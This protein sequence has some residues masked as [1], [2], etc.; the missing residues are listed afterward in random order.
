L[1]LSSELKTIKLYSNDP[2]QEISEVVVLGNFGMKS[3]QITSEMLPGGDLYDIYY[4]NLEL[5]R[6]RLLDNPLQPGQFMI[7]AN[8]KTKLEDDL[9][10]T[11]SL[12]SSS[13][14]ILNIYPNPTQ[15]ILNIVF[16]SRQRYNLTFFDSNGRLVDNNKHEG[17]VLEKDISNYNNGLYYVL[18][19]SESDISLVKIIK[20]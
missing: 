10:L 20:N 7:I 12:E 3:N 18:I 5:D 14:Q 4:N 15:N 16:P 8:G 11:L 13:N 17:I 6:S 2:D 1:N 19:Q 9:S